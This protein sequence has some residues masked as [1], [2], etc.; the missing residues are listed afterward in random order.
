M[1]WGSAPVVAH[2]LV[3]AAGLDPLDWHTDAA[4]PVLSTLGRANFLGSY[5]VLV[6]PLTLRQALLARRW[7]AYRLLIPITSARGSGANPGKGRCL[8]KLFIYPLYSA[9]IHNNPGNPAIVYKWNTKEAMR[10]SGIR[11]ECNRI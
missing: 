9:R 5:L 3:Q 4:S 10:I 7:S 8:D 11:G 2:G 1:V 6:L